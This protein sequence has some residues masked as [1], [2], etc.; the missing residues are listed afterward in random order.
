MTDVLWCVRM[1]TEYFTDMNL[2][3]EYTDA[4]DDNNDHNDLEAM[5]IDKKYM[6]IY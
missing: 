2:A 5:K 3:S 4:H 6:K 1:P